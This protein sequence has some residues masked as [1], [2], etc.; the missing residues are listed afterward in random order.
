MKVA[1]QV[2]LQGNTASHICPELKPIFGICHLLNGVSWS[3]LKHVIGPLMMHTMSIEIIWIGDDVHMLNYCIIHITCTHLVTSLVVSVMLEDRKSVSL[4]PWS[5]GT[6]SKRTFKCTIPP[7]S[8]PPF[9]MREGN[10]EQTGGQ[11]SQL[12]HAL[13]F[14]NCHIFCAHLTTCLRGGISDVAGVSA[15][16]YPSNW[17]SAKGR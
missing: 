1:L 14:M 8:S 4:A 9:E 6:P 16:S 13:R 5:L 10:W 2:C 3:S 15:S 11:V 7:Y 17:K 12:P